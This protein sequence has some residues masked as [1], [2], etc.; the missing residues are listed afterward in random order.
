M[1]D[2][3]YPDTRPEPETRIALGVCERDRVWRSHTGHLFKWA[4]WNSWLMQR[5]GTDE[6]VD[7]VIRTAIADQRTPF[8]VT[9]MDP[10]DG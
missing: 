8:T 6:W 2:S 1:A 9:E 5:A 4:P 10:A 7:L 3:P